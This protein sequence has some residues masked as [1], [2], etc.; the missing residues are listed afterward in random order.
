MDSIIKN[1][2]INQKWCIDNTLNMVYNVK[3]CGFARRKDFLKMKRLL[4]LFLAALMCISIAS[5]SSKESE[6]ELGGAVLEGYEDV[7][8]RK[9]IRVSCEN[10][11]RD[12]KE[13]E[14]LDVTVTSKFVSG[15]NTDKFDERDYVSSKQAAVT[16]SIIMKGSMDDR[17]MS[18][19]QDYYLVHDLE[20]NTL[21]V[22]G[23]RYYST[24]GKN[25]SE[26]F[27]KGNDALEELKDLLRC[28]NYYD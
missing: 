27:D 13:D 23:C 16:C 7:P 17:S 28:Y 19:T 3:K 2:T 26:S 21:K 6:P 12:M 11:E 4:I 24:D 15:W 8:F 20:S 14:G 22:I 25:K 10:A 18:M 5:C 9:L 1:L